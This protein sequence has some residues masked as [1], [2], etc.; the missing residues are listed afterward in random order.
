M[1]SDSYQWIYG[2]F[3]GKKG[4]SAGSFAGIYKEIMYR[5]G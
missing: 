4:F 5:Y 1:A 3:Q 2:N